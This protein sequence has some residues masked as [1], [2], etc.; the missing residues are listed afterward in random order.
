MI[1]P[2][3]DLEGGRARTASRMAWPMPVEQPA[4]AMVDMVGVVG[5]G[6]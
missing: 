5:L 6:V 3:R 4:M 1:V 2:M